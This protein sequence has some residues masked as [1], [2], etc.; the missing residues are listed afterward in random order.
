MIPGNGWVSMAHLL[1]AVLRVTG[2]VMPTRPGRPPNH[3]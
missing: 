3:P 1:A 2:F